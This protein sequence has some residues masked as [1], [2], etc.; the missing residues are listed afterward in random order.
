MSSEHAA[1]Q[2]RSPH[3]STMPS[4]DLSA[5]ANSG[6]DG[7]ADPQLSAALSAYD[8]GIGGSADVVDVLSNCRLLV[9]VVA[10]ADSVGESAD[11]LPTDMSSHLATV[12]T[13]GRDG[14]RGLLAFSS[15]ETMRAWNP[16]ARP[17]PVPTRR[18]A[19][20]ALA[21]GADALV[22]DLAGPVTFSVDAADLR[23]LASGWR[24]V[25]DGQGGTAWA[26]AVGLAGPGP[27]DAD[28]DG[29][30]TAP[31][32]VVR[33]VPGSA[34]VRLVRTRAGAAR[35]L[36]AGVVSAVKRRIR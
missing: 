30:Q 10:V 3:V 23:A 2:L 25:N 17:V 1:E 29:P 7:S 24:P 36:A 16:S 34:P 32:A 13:T 4:R 15:T 35:R 28:E 26:V 22:I 19:E 18:A 27:G 8:S 21:D 14:R 31:L 9:P 12:L 5:G 11:G 6:D 33:D 20:S